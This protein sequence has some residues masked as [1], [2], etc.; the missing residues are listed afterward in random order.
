VNG[1]DMR[2]SPTND[3]LPNGLPV[4]V[5]TIAARVRSQPGVRRSAAN[6]LYPRPPNHDVP[7]RG[8]RNAAVTL[9]ALDRRARHGAV[10]AEHAAVAGQRLERLA[11][12]FAQVEEPAGIGRHLLGRS[13]PA[14]RTSQCRF[15]LHQ[16]CS[17]RFRGDQPACPVIDILDLHPS[18]LVAS[19]QFSFQALLDLNFILSIRAANPPAMPCGNAKITTMSSD[20]NII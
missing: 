12:A 1:S 17:L 10:G 3:Y 2:S 18:F 7:L 5:K 11:A 6:R 15:E 19:E 13:V 8:V 14:A 9:P 20:P 4:Q 16:G